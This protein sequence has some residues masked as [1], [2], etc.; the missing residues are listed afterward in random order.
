MI[1]IEHL[2]RLAPRPES[3]RTAAVWDAY[4]AA[5]T[6]EPAALM[7]E[8][9]I[10]TAL[11]LQ[12]FM[13]QIAHE[14]DGFTILWENM[15]YRAPR[16]LE[17]FGQGRH[18]AAVTASEAERLAGNPEALAERVYG[19]GNARKA[20]ELGNVQPG[21]G[22]RFR[23]FGPMQ[24][25]GR[26][27]H[28]R[29]LG[30]EQTVRAA[31]TAALREWDEKR[32]N[33]C[34]AR[35]DLK[36]ITKRIN[37]G[38]NGLDSRRAYLAKAKRIWPKLEADT[39]LPDPPASMLESKTGNTAVLLGSGGSVQVGTEIAG[40]VSR[41]AQSGKPFTLAE[42]LIGLAQSPTFWVGVVVVGG[43]AF[44]WLER[45]LKLIRWGI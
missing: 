30:G 42:L 23:G 44:I 27:D 41:V 26:R 13:A 19:L 39:H 12:H 8:H 11:E 16:I 28:E 40:A 10:D 36:T 7:A 45:R 5:L 32:C 4:A 21:D 31:L 33:E 29:L 1:T 35:D 25:T 17:I 6:D 14:S 24:I 18:S 15:N 20:R 38:Y 37:G 22:Y 3:L 2:Q 34:A 9:G 43:A